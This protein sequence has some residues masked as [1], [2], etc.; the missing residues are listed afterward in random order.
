MFIP[1]QELAS[2]GNVFAKLRASREKKGELAPPEKFGSSRAC[3]VVCLFVC[4]FLL[5]LMLLMFLSLG[6]LCVKQ[7]GFWVKA[8][9]A[10]AFQA[11]HFP[12]SQRKD[13]V[14]VAFF[15]TS[16]KKNCGSGGCL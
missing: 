3:L 13:K 11:P 12:L 15:A 10:S 4:L 1:G 6:R 7:A 8:F 16:S 2:T 5:L 14:H 9:S